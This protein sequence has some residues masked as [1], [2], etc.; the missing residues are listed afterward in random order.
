ML[1][2]IFF[3]TTAPAATIAFFPITF[4]Q[5]IVAFAPSHT[6]VFIKFSL[7]FGNLAF[8]YKSFVNTQEGKKT[9]FSNITPSYIQTLLCIFTSFPI[10][11]L[12]PIYTFCPIVQF[13]QF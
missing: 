6:K 3:V 11:T 10:C 9:P 4:P 5:T 8:G 7:P 1:S 12:L 2:S 13:F